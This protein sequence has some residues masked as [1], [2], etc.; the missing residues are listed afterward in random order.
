MQERRVGERRADPLPGLTQYLLGLAEDGFYGVVEVQY[1]EGEI[2]LV[3][4]QESFKPSFF[5]K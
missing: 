1:Q 3:R 5:V 2:V 4:K